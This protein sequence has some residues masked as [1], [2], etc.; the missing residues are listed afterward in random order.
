MNQISFASNKSGRKKLADTIASHLGVRAEYTGTPTFDYQIGDARLD[1]DWTLHLP[2]DIN[3]EALIEAT[4][5]AGFV[6]TSEEYGLTLAFPTTDWDEATAAKLEALL[7]AKGELIVKALGISATPMNLNA[8][9]GTVEF[10]WFDQLPEAEVIEAASVLLQLMIEHAKT[11]TRISP[12]PPE[13]G[14]DKYAMRCWLLRLGMIG[15]NYKH[16]RRVLLA[17]LEGNAAWKT[18]PKSDH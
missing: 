1:R 6:P 8:V 2:Q 17:N 7:A 5:E 14:N 11:S 15:D 12:K 10:A 16:V 13:P 3:A 4:Q 18:L 9:E